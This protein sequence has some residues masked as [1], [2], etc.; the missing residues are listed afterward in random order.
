VNLTILDRIVLARAL[1]PEGSIVEVRTCLAIAKKIELDETETERWIDK[2]S[3]NPKIGCDKEETAESFEF[4]PE[5]N[6]LIVNVLNSLDKNHRINQHMLG[7]VA[8]F[9][10]QEN[11]ED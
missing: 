9:L 2:T 8:I 1:P 5:E 3:G 11:E 6:A 10:E 7:L 4:S